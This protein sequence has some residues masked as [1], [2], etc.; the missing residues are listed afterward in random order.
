MR[1]AVVGG[2]VAGALLAW[3]LRTVAVDLYTAPTNDATGASGGLVRGFDGSR[4]AAESLVELLGDARLR[5]AA[6]YHEIGSLYLRSADPSPALG[7]LDELLPGSASVLSEAEV[8]A[9]YPFRDLPSGTG[10]VVERRAG[11]LSPAALRTAALGWVAEAGAV[12]RSVPVVGVAPYPAL[13]LADGSTEEYDAVVIATGAWTPALLAA[14]GLA[15]G[16][17]ATKQI[18]YAV[19]ATRP[20]GIC[21][22]VDDETGLYG[23]P[24]GERGFLLGLPCDRWHVNPARLEPDTGLVSRT[25]EVAG[26]MFGW[27]LVDDRPLRTVVAADCYHDQAGLALR[28]VV[29]RTSVFT[30][31]GGSGGAARTVLA[32]S[33]QAADALLG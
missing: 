24:F 33:R 29:R 22:F 17:L 27:P 9:R 5:E 19:Y 25:A 3:R 6:D 28:P 21:A 10:A 26:K 11:Y 13:R 31:T 18:Q 14:S 4:L 1:I 20:D 8:R 23:R 32:A 15:T 30:F 16:G 12:I 7:V 2:G